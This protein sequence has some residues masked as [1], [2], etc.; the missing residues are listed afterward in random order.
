METLL[1]G[2]GTSWHVDYTGENGTEQTSY[3]SLYVN[4]ETGEVLT[5]YH[6]YEVTH[7]ISQNHPNSVGAAF[8]I[9][10]RRLGYIDLTVNKRWVDGRIRDGAPAE[11]IALLSDDTLSDQIGQELLQI[12]NDALDRVFLSS[13]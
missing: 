2:E 1:E 4:K 13:C 3:D 6:R 12:Y 5:D 10:N 8:T 9:S 7:E 11:E